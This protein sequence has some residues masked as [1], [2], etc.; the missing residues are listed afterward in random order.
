MQPLRFHQFWDNVWG[1]FQFIAMLQGEKNHRM[2][3]PNKSCMPWP[4]DQL[5]SK[6]TWTC[7]LHIAEFLDQW[8]IP[9][10]GWESQKGNFKNLCQVTLIEE[11]WNGRGYEWINTVGKMQ[12]KGYL[13][14]TVHYLKTR[15]QTLLICHV[16]DQGMHFFS[17]FFHFPMAEKCEYLSPLWAERQASN[18]EG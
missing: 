6:A 4:L 10:F 3:A 7:V 5:G 13:Y 12:S 16:N 8:H 17:K 2:T 14:L 1:Q 9:S 18:R 15:K 11:K